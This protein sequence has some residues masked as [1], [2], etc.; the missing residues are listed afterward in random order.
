MNK[1]EIGEL[2][3]KIL[4]IC[5]F[6][7][8]LNALHLPIAWLQT[9]TQVTD[10]QMVWIL[11]FIPSVLLFLFSGILWLS[12]K[13]PK[14][15][16]QATADS[17]TN[18]STITPDILLSMAF[19]VTGIFVLIG[20]LNLLPNFLSQLIARIQGSYRGDMIRFWLGIAIIVIRLALGCWLLFGTKGMQI[21][22]TRLLQR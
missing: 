11:S 4:S 13:T 14:A 6:I 1:S 9:G 7:G 17:P 5:A 8:A 19:S 16:S 20:T 10:N 15:D 21:L 12:T 2:S 18:T 3:L 22:K